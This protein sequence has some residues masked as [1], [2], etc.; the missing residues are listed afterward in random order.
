ME[1]DCSDIGSWKSISE[2]DAADERGNRVRGAAILVDSDDCYVQSDAQ[3][4]EFLD[5][6]DAYCAFF[7]GEAGGVASTPMEFF[8]QLRPTQPPT[9]VTP[10]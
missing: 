7:L 2:L 3:L 4:R 9:G 1:I 6:I 10:R 8:T 5:R